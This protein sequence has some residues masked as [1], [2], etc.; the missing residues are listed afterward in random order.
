MDTTITMGQVSRGFYSVLATRLDRAMESDVATYESDDAIIIVE[1][2]AKAQ[3]L[4]IY[5]VEWYPLAFAGAEAS[6]AASS[7]GVA[8]TASLCTDGTNV[9]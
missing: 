8:Y 9:L 7:I 6:I 2:Y 1:G 4:A 5:G 3:Y